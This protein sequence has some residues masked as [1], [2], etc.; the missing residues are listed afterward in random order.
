MLPLIVHPCVDPQQGEQSAEWC[1]ANESV[2]SAVLRPISERLPAATCRDCACEGDHAAM[3]CGTMYFIH[4]RSNLDVY[5]IENRWFWAQ[6]AGSAVVP[7]TTIGKETDHPSFYKS[8][9][10]CGEHE[11]K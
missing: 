9:F 6:S 1:A 3:E 5:P 2:H 4:A 8:Q 11:Y 10:S 7:C